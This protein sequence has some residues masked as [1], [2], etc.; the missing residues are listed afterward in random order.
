MGIRCLVPTAAEANQYSVGAH[1]GPLGS[2]RVGRRR[3]TRRRL[4]I[5]VCCI[6]GLAS[7]GCGSSTSAT[8]GSK[9]RSRAAS[10]ATSAT[11]MP[12]CGK[13]CELAG[14]AGG[15]NPAECP[16]SASS[17]RCRSCPPSGC[18]DLSSTSVPVR[19]GVAYFRVK[20]RL[21]QPCVGALLVFQANRL[22][23][24]GTPLPEPP[25][26]RVAQ[27]DL[28]VAAN[29]QITVAVRL[30]GLGRK[31]VSQASSGYQAGA[32]IALDPYGPVVPAGPGTGERVVLRSS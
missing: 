30:T 16:S 11:P 4:V 26:V 31:L 13:Y 25:S 10:S 27:G 22:T 1:I 28:R 24:S 15:P 14:P 17:G 19:G 6:G 7:I 32:Y 8:T 3:E 29:S 2:P 9:G 20:C 12:T 5:A 21:A 18:M 23:S